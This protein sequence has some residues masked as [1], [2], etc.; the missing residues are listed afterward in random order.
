MLHCSM[1]W[2]LPEHVVTIQTILASHGYTAYLVGGAVRNRLGGFG[3]T[4]Y[5]I[6]TDAPAEKMTSMFRRVIPTGLS[7]GTVTLLFGNEKYEVTTFRIDGNYSDARHPDYVQFTHDIK[8]DLARRDFTVNGIAYDIQ[9]HQIIDPYD[10]VAD[11]H[12]KLLRTIGNPYDRFSED[13]LRILRAV[14]FVSQLGFTIDDV[15]LS[16]MKAS[17]PDLLHISMERVR[18]EFVKLL[19]GKNA[20]TAIFLMESTGILSILLPEI[21]AL[22]GLEQ[23]GFHSFDVFEHSVYS[24]EWAPKDNLNV[25]LASLFHDIGKPASLSVKDGQRTFYHHEQVGAKMTEAIL[26]RFKFSNNEIKDVSHLVREHMFHYT[27]DWSDGAVR[28]FIRRVGLKYLEDLF[29]LRRCDEY[30]FSRSPLDSP[31]LIELSKRIRRILK[32][33][34]ALSLKDL[35]IDGTI[36]H[37]EL[38]I[39]K[40]RIMGVVLQELLETVID[41][42]SLNNRNELIKIAERIY[43]SIKK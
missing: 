31:G 36:L 26:S 10:G 16:A 37:T 35:A 4:D 2:K 38:Q 40:T 30:G 17:T 1:M 13:P 43:L 18:D 5:D 24:F 33:K 34:D 20:V 8:E 41:D 22:K 7:H 12:N 19:K 14:R 39:P 32:Q 21:S 28:R 25:L 6:A 29:I 11:I 23:K 42:P 3:I 27:S 15:T 9:K